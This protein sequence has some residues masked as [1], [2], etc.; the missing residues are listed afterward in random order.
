MDNDT[1]YGGQANDLVD[2][3]EGNDKLSRT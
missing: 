1:L 3:N 2:G